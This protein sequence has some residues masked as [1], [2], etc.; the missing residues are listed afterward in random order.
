MKTLSIMAL[1]VYWSVIILAPVI[2]NEESKYSNKI[3]YPKKKPN[4]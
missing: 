1:L 3:V 2:A 4:K